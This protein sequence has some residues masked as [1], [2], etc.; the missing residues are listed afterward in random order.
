VGYAV[1]AMFPYR[2]ENETQRPPYFIIIIIALNALV[3]LV[4]EGAGA[5]LAVARAVCDLG[6]IPG[7]LTGTLPPG[8]RF[9]IGEGLAS[10]TPV[11]RSLT[12]SPRCSCTVP[13][14][15]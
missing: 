7:E 10:S 3:W 2:D 13:V 5:S 4:V 12:C 15:T 9:P 14:C 8:T 1:R 6:L 11:D